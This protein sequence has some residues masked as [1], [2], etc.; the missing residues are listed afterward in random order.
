MTKVQL[1]AKYTKVAPAILVKGFY[2]TGPGVIQ[3][4]ELR[5]NLQNDPKTL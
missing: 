2:R 5:C 3:C 1:E 4:K